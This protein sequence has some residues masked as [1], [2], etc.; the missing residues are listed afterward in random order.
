MESRGEIGDSFPPCNPVLGVFSDSFCAV[1][2]VLGCF[3]RWSVPGCVSVRGLGVLRRLDGRPARVMRPR[4]GGLWG[5]GP[6]ACPVEEAC[7]S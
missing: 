2:R 7:E 1:E 6:A 4:P 5:K 3:W